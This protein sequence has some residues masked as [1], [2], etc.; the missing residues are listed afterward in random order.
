MQPQELRSMLFVTQTSF[1]KI[2]RL[3]PAS[4]A[5]SPKIHCGFTYLLIGLDV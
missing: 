3:T 2:Y 5:S 4:A 1:K